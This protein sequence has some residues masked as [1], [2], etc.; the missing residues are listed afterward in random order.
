[1]REISVEPEVWE[2]QRCESLAA[3]LGKICDGS[4]MADG[5][6]RTHALA[7]FAAE[8]RGTGLFEQ[9]GV[10]LPLS[11]VFGRLGADAEGRLLLT[12]ALMR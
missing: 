12:G 11:R 9:R 6:E 4:G 8:H 7:R 2:R 1:M 10:K 3:K 5:V